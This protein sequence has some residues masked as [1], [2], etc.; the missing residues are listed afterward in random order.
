MVRR[1]ESSGS[2]QTDGAQANTSQLPSI[3]ENSLLQLHPPQRHRAEE[4]QYLLWPSQ[5]CQLKD[6]LATALE[7]IARLTRLLK[8]ASEEAE[9]WREEHVNLTEA[10]WEL[11]E[12]ARA[13]KGQCWT[14]EE[15]VKFLGGAVAR[16]APNPNTRM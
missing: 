13:A 7:E 5:V 16:E 12:E 3:P 10:Y 6:N 15:R 4:G 9:W 1:L 2:S 8:R 14:L 11:N